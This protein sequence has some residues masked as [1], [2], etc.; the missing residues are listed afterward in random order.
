MLIGDHWAVELDGFSKRHAAGRGPGERVMA[1]E[2]LTLKLAPGQILGLLGPN[3]SGKTTTLKALAGLL[4]PTT[5]RCRIMGAE[6]GSTGAR[7]L[8]G[9]LP[10]AVRFAPHQTG[11]E[12]LQYC[13]GLSSLPPARAEARIKTVLAWTALGP[14]AGRRIATY[15]KGMAQRL[16]LAQAV[17]HEPRVVLLDEPTSGLDPE[18]RLALVRLIRDLAGQ[19]CAVVLTSHLL[20]QAEEVCDRLALLGRGRLLVSGPTAELLGAQTRPVA[21]ASRLEELYLEKIHADV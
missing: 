2:G 15:S 17:L 6:A 1:V 10:E 12:F 16:G 19:G 11:E 14:A 9:Y 7:A 3:G 13:A 8:V 5:G 20:A 4:V 18:G 21:G